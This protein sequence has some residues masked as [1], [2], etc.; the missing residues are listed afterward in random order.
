MRLRSLCLLV[1]LLFWAQPAVALE[2]SQHDS[3]APV[4]LEADQLSFDEARGLY[5]AQGKARLSQGAVQLTSDQLWWNKQTGEVEASG[6][7]RVSGPAEVLTGKRITYNLQQ[8]TGVVEEGEAFWQTN[9]LRVSGQRL[10]RLGPNRF[11][12]YKGHFTLC[13]SADP[14]WS[15]GSAVADVTIGRYLTAK[16]AL[17]YIKGIPAFYLPYV[18]LPIKTERESG[19][20]VSRL[21]VSD[22]KGTEFSTA[23]YQVLGRNMDATFYLDHMSRLG[24]GAGLEYRYI[25]G[26][27]Q[28]G[29]FS[30]YTVFAKDGNNPWA[31]DWEHFGQLGDDTRLV[32]DAEYVNGTGYFSDYG[33]IAP[34]YN[35][36]KVISSLFVNRRWSKA[37]LTAQYKSI[38]DLEADDPQP[39][40]SAPLLDYSIAPWRIGKT[41]LYLGLESSYVNFRRDQGAS[42]QRLMLRPTLGVH[43]FLFKGIEFD[44]EYSY[45]Q[46]QYFGIEPDLAT[47]SGSSATRAR[48]SSSLSRVYGGGER[49]WLHGIEPEINYN[50]SEENL[51][52]ELPA[53]DR[54]DRSAERNTLG[55]AFVTRLT[56]KWLG[57]EGAET[58]REVAWLKLSQDYDLNAAEDVEP[59]TDLRIQLITK[60]TTHSEL[61]LDLSYDMDLNRIPDFTLDGSLADGRG[62]SLGVAYHKH[63]PV[64]DVGKVDNLN[65]NFDIALLKPLYLH[66]EQRYDLLESKRLEQVL[67]LDLRQQC[68]GLNVMLRDREEERSIMFT[69]TLSGI[70]EVGRFGR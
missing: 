39:W 11:R 69:L 49:S 61:G 32:A 10:E 52:A 24:T 59:F 41:P 13:D 54:Y 2:L 27:K 12:V 64:T 36:Q 16:H 33:E 51:F 57:T 65:F 46:R 48:L 3:D 35:K 9:S 43:G 56:G 40:Q 67:G 60:P 22:K 8:G 5:H 70:G 38:K 15:L 17:V 18:V 14:A 21:N 34:E 42:G 37:S 53:F 30:A 7:A 26:R 68:W 6:N 55:Y 31:F 25:F 4:D 28:R 62:N 1:L 47:S 19:F 29:E 23:W 50:W 20:L 63:L 66:Y 58:Q 45:R 44:S